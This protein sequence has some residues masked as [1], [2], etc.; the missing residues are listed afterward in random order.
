MHLYRAAINKGLPAL[1]DLTYSRLGHPDTSIGGAAD[2]RCVLM[3][4]FL[5]M[6]GKNTS[7]AGRKRREEIRSAVVERFAMEIWER[8]AEGQFTQMCA[9]SVDFAEKMLECAREVVKMIM[10]GRGV[11]LDELD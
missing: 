9:D 10:K 8:M 4:A 6:I 7:T 2:V 3:I 5:A 1:A 11:D